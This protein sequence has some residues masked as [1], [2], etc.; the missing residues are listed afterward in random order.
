MTKIIPFLLQQG[1]RWRKDKEER[2]S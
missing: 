2:G 1:L